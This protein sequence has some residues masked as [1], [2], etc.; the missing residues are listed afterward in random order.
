M[1]IFLDTASVKEIKDILPWGIITGITT[2][3]KIFLAEKGVN[4][5]DRVLEILSLVDGPISVELTKTAENDDELIKEAK[6]YSHWSPKNIVIKVPMFGDGRG[7]RI[8]NRLKKEKIKTNMTCMITTNQVMLAAKAGATYASIF[9]NRVKDSGLDPNKV[10][11]ESKR[12]IEKGHLRTKIIVG[13]IRK[14]EDVT[15]A[16]VAGAHIITIP[17]KILVQMPFHQKTEDTCKEFD[18]AWTEFKKAETST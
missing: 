12:I 3:Q 14:P 6:E 17:Y 10:I 13:S 5:K 15:E 16:A 7:L 8:V 1:E 9:Y 18:Q 4:F 2:N 11:E